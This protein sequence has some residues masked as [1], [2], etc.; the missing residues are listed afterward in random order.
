MNTDVDLTTCDTEPIHVPGSIQPHGALL[1]FDEARVLV[2]RSRGAAEL[3]GHPLVIGAAGAGLAA[4]NP[5]ASV[6]TQALETEG[7]PFDVVLGGTTFDV[8][9]H[10]SGERRIV[11][12]EPR[13]DDA[14][15]LHAFAIQAQHALA[16]LPRV[17][18]LS[19][20]F[21]EI[22]REVRRL[23]GFDRVMFYRFR[24]DDAGEVVAE[25][26]ADELEPFLGLRYPASDIP[27]QA[28]R[29]Y[30]VNPLR[31]IADVDAAPAVLEPPSGPDAE[32]PL[33][34]SHA[35]LRSSSPIHCEY[36]RNMGVR[37][38]MSISIV[39]E[40]K[41]W[42]LVACHHYRG[43]K[44]VPH[45]VRA[46]A[47]VLAQ[48][49]SS[50]I[51][52]LEARARAKHAQETAKTVSA[53]A[54]A[55][56]AGNDLIEAIVAT[57]LLGALVRSTGGAMT[58]EKRVDTWG[59]APPPATILAL[60]EGGDQ[61]VAVDDL[62]ARHGA[63]LELGGAA[64]MLAKRYHERNG[65]LIWFRKEEAEEIRWGGNP[66]KVYAEGPHGTRLSPR[67]SFAEYKQVVRG[68]SEAWAERDREVARTV[69]AVVQDVAMHRLSEIHKT[70]E[71][72]MA[73]LSHDLKNPLN[74]IGLIAGAMGQDSS[75][76]AQLSETI[77]RS[78]GRM[79]R[80]ID[81]MLDFSRIRAHGALGVQR[82]RVDVAALVRE[83]V[84]EVTAA[85]PGF[86]IGV[87]CPESLVADVDPDRIAQAIGNL[88][89]NA[90][91]HGS[92]PT[93]AEL[94]VT[95]EHRSEQGF[96]VVTVRNAG[97]PLSD[98]TKSQL[99]RAFNSA[100]L[101]STKRSGLGLGLFIVH[102]IVAEHGGTIEAVNEPGHVAFRFAIPLTSSPRP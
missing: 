58:F 54:N 34:L 7:D 20:L 11:E 56:R 23:T 43:P 85:F 8:V 82:E 79:Q 81:Q 80:L 98:E 26:K 9:A 48:L 17:T 69:R 45:A 31:F 71:L 32:R 6:I 61:V 67:G 65:W 73:A 10:R 22:T 60:V 55:A 59:D 94:L 92:P 68:R 35:L 39:V 87:T 63:T 102:R 96:L 70:R 100:T 16:R 57:D 25:D 38:S 99:F 88:L 46:S 42:G 64:G 37:A 66:D 101:A 77:T 51:E 1:A 52:Q 83:I 41:L 27:A 2:A 40:Q 78:A 4:G 93:R 90:R 89:S 91:H 86:T 84:A 24:H 75:R 49:A 14:P 18:D 44:R 53:L 50:R 5:L 76:S 29:L 95:E 28:R 74:A 72:L 97:G 3:L 12:L 36:L 13:A 47:S 33:D 30:L 21:A 62:P 15:P 19:S